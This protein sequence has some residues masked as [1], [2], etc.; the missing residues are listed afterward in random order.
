MLIA[1]LI[2][3][4][5]TFAYAGES[6]G[7]FQSSSI[8]KSQSG[9]NTN[10]VYWNRVISEQ[11]KSPTLR[12]G[13]SDFAVEGSLISGLSQRA[14]EPNSSVGRKLFSLPVVRL[15]V[16]QPVPYPPEGGKYFRWGE[17]SRPWV[18][19]AEAG[20]GAGADNAVNHEPQAVL[21]S[22]GR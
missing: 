1:I 5:A 3:S 17:S 11:T 6:K 9:W 12:I 14:V 16:P 15:F 18:S 21:F 13:K 20:G 8:P 19:I 22:I 4:S 2:I 10:L 7:G